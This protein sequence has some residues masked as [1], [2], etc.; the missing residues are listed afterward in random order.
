MSLCLDCNLF[1]VKGTAVK[2]NKYVRIF[3]MWLSA[4]RKY[5][6]LGAADLL[7]LKIDTDTFDYLKTNIAFNGLINKNIC[8]VQIS[9]YPPPTTIREGMIMRYMKV[10]EMRDAYMYCDID[11]LI[12]KPLRP[13]YESLPIN[14]IRVHAEG[15]LSDNNYGEAFTD[16]EKSKLSLHLP[17]FSSG[18]FIIHGKELYS[19]F[20][21]M[22]M[23]LYGIHDNRNYYTVDQPLFNRALYGLIKDPKQFSCIPPTFISSNG[24]QFTT[25]CI[26]LDAMGMPGDGDLH[27]NKMLDYYTLLQS[28]A[29]EAIFLKSA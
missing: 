20:V 3:I 18:K 13:L 10:N 2:E 21:E 22:I 1:T 15:K 14:T 17:G 25:E 24:H 12:I 29:L 4:L 11:I 8:P 16:E 9:L 19:Q 6:G 28:D 27:F 26:L 5:G 23:I 7:H